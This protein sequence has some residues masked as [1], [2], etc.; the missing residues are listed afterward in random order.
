MYFKDP[1]NATHHAVT[2][3]QMVF[4]VLGLFIYFS[5]RFIYKRLGNEATVEYQEGG[6][7]TFHLIQLC[8][9]LSQ[10]NELM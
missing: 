9:T 5:T 8:Q 6:W 4:G 7:L 3:E 10:G 1:P 2:A